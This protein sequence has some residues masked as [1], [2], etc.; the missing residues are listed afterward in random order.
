[1]HLIR[2]GHLFDPGSGLDRRADLYIEDGVIAGIGEAPA[3][4]DA[5]KAETHS[6]EDMT[7]LPGLVDCRARL[8]GGEAEAGNLLRSETLAAA[9][10]GVTTAL[11]P[12]TTDFLLDKPS[13]VAA[14]RGTGERIS[15]VRILPICNLLTDDGTVLAEMGSLRE[16]GSVGAGNSHFIADSQV[17][18]SAIRYAHTFD[19][20]IC[21]TARDSALGRGYVHL[22]ALSAQLGL[23]V[24]PEVAET[25]EVARWLLL[26]E[27]TGCK[28]HLATL[29]TARA[30]ELVAAARDRGQ[31]VTAD[32]PIH[33]LL[34]T[35]ACIADYDSAY[36]L[37]PPLRSESD[38]L[39]LLEGV[40]SGLL[41]IC[42]NHRPLV[43]TAKYEVFG[44]GEPGAA[45]IETVLALGLKLVH[46]GELTLEQLVRSLTSL[47]AAAFGLNA[48]S[49]AIGA[50]ADLCLLHRD[51]QWQ[52]RPEQLKT[53]G[54][55]CI[56]AGQE[57][58]G[59][60]AGTFCAGRP[61]I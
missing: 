58:T 39:A 48:G 45:S 16:Q 3:G 17:L 9:A 31:Q 33:N 32:V 36:H 29:S 47:P 7:V 14:L 8:L 22:G 49:M 5:N 12:P 40:R 38:R 25:L 34:L 60:V 43:S 53:S 57:L 21:A 27:K 13:A 52:V 41:A 55:N 24:V 54:E 1:M 10:G 6:A 2:G 26:A 19:L 20:P 30:V 61:H 11:V 28:L 4:F 50:P 44:A 37:M 59:Q 46:D 15:E 42:S 18:L 51:A 56:E 23:P 35:D